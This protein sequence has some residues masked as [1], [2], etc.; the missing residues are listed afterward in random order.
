MTDSRRTCSSTDP[1]HSASPFT[2]HPLNLPMPT[3]FVFCD[4]TILHYADVGSCGGGGPEPILIPK[5]REI[6]MFMAWT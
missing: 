5:W 3:L 4:Q 1:S 6:I 2:P